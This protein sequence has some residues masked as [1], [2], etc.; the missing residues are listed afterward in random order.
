MFAVLTIFP[1]SMKIKTHEKILKTGIGLC[2]VKSYFKLILYHPSN[3]ILG[4]E[5]FWI[6]SSR[7]LL[8]EMTTVMFQSFSINNC[9]MKTVMIKKS[10]Y[11]YIVEIL[12]QIWLVGANFYSLCWFVQNLKIKSW[13]NIFINVAINSYQTIW[14]KQEAN[15]DIIIILLALTSDVAVLIGCFHYK[16]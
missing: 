2:F 6:L 15:I 12:V 14:L 1:I 13:Q 3:K 5:E 4:V 10:I 8:Y 7:K 11:M 9:S 16:K